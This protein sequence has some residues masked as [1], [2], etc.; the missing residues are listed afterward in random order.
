MCR[1]SGIVARSLLTSATTRDTLLDETQFDTFFT[2]FRQLYAAG[3]SYIA[4][5]I[6]G[7]PSGL[8]IPDNAVN[9]AWRNADLYLIPF[10]SWASNSTWEEINSYSQEFTEDWLPIITNATAGSGAYASEGDILEPDFKQSFYGLAKY[11]R[12]LEIKQKYDPTGLFYAHKGV[13]SDEWYI[14]DQLPGL[15][16]QNGRL[17]RV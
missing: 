11:E 15:P 14:T 13:G 3:G 12:L 17:C 4:Y 2:A 16:T 8:D 5:T 7:G 10:R 1:S 6:T 9:P